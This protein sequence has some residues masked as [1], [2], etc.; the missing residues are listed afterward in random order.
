LKVVQT[1]SMRGIPSYITS[2][3]FFYLGFQVFFSQSLSCPFEYIPQGIRCCAGFQE[4][5]KS[6]AIIFRRGLPLKSHCNIIFNKMHCPAFSRAHLWFLSPLW[7]YEI[8]IDNFF[9]YLFLKRCSQG[10]H[11]HRKNCSSIKGKKVLK[12]NKKLPR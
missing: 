7:K 8:G 11:F 12:T 5:Q 6:S 3:T 2:L 4:F 9:Q 10:S 1:A